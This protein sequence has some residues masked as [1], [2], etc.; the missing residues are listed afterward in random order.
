MFVGNI[1]NNESKGIRY[2]HI[3]LQLIY[4]E[5]QHIY[6]I[7]LEFFKFICKNVWR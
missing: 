1:V 6:I 7:N 2:C 4:C 5:R 3:P